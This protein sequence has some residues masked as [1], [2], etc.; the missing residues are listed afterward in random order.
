MPTRKRTKPKSDV[1]EAQRPTKQRVCI[2]VASRAGKHTRTRPL[3]TNIDVP[4]LGCGG[5]SLGDLYVKISNVQAI[6]TVETAYASNVRFFDTSPWYGV[7]LSEARMGISLH[8]KPRKSFVMQTKVGRHLIPD[9]DAQNGR[10]CGWIGGF[11]NGIRFDYSRE[12][13]E[14]QLSSSLQRMGLG[15]VDSAVIHDLEPTP[16]PGSPKE[17]IECA[18]RDLAVLEA[19][20]W[21]WLVEQRKKGMLRAFGAGLNSHEAGE[22]PKA[23]REWN[24]RYTDEL[25]R[26]GKTKGK[27][28]FLLLANMFSLLN[29]EAW[30]DGILQK[31][32]DANV[33]VVVG[34]PFS[35]GILATGA[36]PKSGSVP[37]Y[38]YQPATDEMRS[39]TR[40][41]EK[42]CERHAVPL[43]AAALQFPLLHPAVCSVIP[44][45]KCP[46]EIES[47]VRNISVEIPRAFWVEAEAKG[48]LPKGLLHETA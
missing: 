9:R 41:L 28:D 3:G 42:L 32:Q 39:R 31:C 10:K 11:H 6:Q 4:V 34:G 22:D 15:Y 19:S 21:T 47:N 2:E 43:I 30:E 5:A 14:R 45:G 26:L 44:G 24:V 20:G 36:D 18:L 48:F 46:T 7:G 8:D 40:T 35:S 38:N 12:G 16:R 23:K 37:F 33:S 29:H 13:F 1:E 27:I 17:K 25:L